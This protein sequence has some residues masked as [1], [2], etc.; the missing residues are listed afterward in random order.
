MVLLYP[1]RLGGGDVDEDVDAAL[2]FA[3]AFAGHARLHI[4]GFTALQYNIDP[5]RR[6]V[7]AA[8]RVAEYSPIIA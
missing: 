5:G 3:A 2:H 7:I 1:G 6:C 4:T 8:I